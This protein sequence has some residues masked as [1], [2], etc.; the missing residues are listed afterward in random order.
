MFSNAL[1]TALVFYFFLLG[2]IWYSVVENS[3]VCT[4]SQMQREH[5]LFG[6]ITDGYVGG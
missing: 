4:G 1:K 6:T 2:L 5:Y 3:Y